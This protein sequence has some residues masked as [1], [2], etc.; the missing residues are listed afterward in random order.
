MC[1]RDIVPAI[2]NPK[3][4]FRTR[5]AAYLSKP[6]AFELL[7]ARDTR[8][9]EWSAYACLFEAV[10]FL[11]SPADFPKGSSCEMQ[12]VRHNNDKLLQGKLRRT[13]VTRYAYNGS[14]QAFV[15]R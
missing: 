13:L 5:V 15:Q 14:A 11:P 7:V 9:A 3:K 6:P 10:P 2:G 1:C 8:A 4:R 12:D